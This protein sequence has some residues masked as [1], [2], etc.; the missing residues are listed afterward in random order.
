MTT[1]PRT[2]ADE[3][4]TAQSNEPD[5]APV[6]YYGRSELPQQDVS[7]HRFSLRR[8]STLIASSLFATLVFLI[9]LTRIH[10]WTRT[11]GVRTLEGGVRKLQTRWPGLEF[12]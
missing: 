8:K 3:T 10:R 12:G 1:T 5:T 11:E 7:L 4:S 2:E 9:A 6:Q